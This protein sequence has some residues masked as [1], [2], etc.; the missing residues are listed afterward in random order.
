MLV[1]LVT[2]PLPSRTVSVYM[3]LPK[4]SSLLLSLKLPIAMGADGVMEDAL[5]AEDD[6]NANSEAWLETSTTEVLL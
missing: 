4:E 2:L 5:V 6:L 3:L 1:S